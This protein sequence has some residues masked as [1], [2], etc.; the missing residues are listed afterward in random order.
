MEQE[1]QT[2]R[3]SI[4]CG[5]G[6]IQDL[7][8]HGARSSRPATDEPQEDPAKIGFREFHVQTG[9]EKRSRSHFSGLH[10]EGLNEMKSMLFSEKYMVP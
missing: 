7:Y 4:R 8:R 9:S 10:H 3:I 1:V 2:G 5:Q 6:S